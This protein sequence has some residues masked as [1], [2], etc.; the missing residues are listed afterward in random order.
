MVLVHLGGQGDSM[1]KG[2]SL[3]PYSHIEQL[4]KS[5]AFTGRR[6]LLHA[7]CDEV[8]A[9]QQ[10]LRVVLSRPEGQCPPVLPARQAAP[11][12]GQ[13]MS[14]INTYICTYMCRCTST[15]HL[16]TYLQTY[17]PTYTH[18]YIYTYLY[19]YLHATYMTLHT[20][21]HTCMCVHAFLHTGVYIYTY[22]HACL[23][24]Y[25]HIFIPMDL[26]VCLYIHANIYTY[27]K[28][29][30]KYKGRFLC[31]ELYRTCSAKVPKNE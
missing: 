16:H 28:H 11:E 29:T 10:Q 6:S 20:Y 5:P 19:T 12:T 9:L 25:M 17:I 3:P 27:I 24:F 1:S 26:H 31:F 4:C 7:C 23:H 22:M 21:V 30:C 2:D 8:T 15:T 14:L 13:L 18:A